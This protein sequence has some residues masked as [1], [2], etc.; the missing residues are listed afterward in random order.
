MESKSSYTGKYTLCMKCLSLKLEIV[1]KM[2]ALDEQCSK[3]TTNKS[4]NNNLWKSERKQSE[5]W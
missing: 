2:D 5:L 4:W 3:Y 1:I